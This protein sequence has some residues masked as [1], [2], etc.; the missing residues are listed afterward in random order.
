MCKGGPHFVSVV[1]QER[2][3]VSAQEDADISH[4]LE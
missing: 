4:L 3:K 2:K 1:Y